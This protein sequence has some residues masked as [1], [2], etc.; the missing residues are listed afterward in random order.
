MTRCKAKIRPRTASQLDPDP[1]KKKK[2]S[3]SLSVAR[4]GPECLS[5]NYNNFVLYLLKIFDFD[6]YIISSIFF[7]NVVQLSSYILEMKIQI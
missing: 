4:S 3:R 6:E 1:L 2:M 5:I 7:T